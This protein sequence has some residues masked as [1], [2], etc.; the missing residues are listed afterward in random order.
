MSKRLVVVALKAG[1]RHAALVQRAAEID[2]EGYGPLATVGL[3]AGASAPEVIVNEIIDAFRQRYDATVELAEM[4]EEN[5]HFP[6]NREL[7]NIELTVADM[8]FVNGE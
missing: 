7:R 4:A 8:A 6:V 1:A 3:S 2:W 5:E